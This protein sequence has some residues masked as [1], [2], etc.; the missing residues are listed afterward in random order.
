MMKKS[1]HTYS[2]NSKQSQRS[3]QKESKVSINL[4]AQE[5]RHKA[6]LQKNRKK[7][8]IIKDWHYY[9][10]M[11]NSWN[12]PATFCKKQYS[13]YHK[14]KKENEKK[15]ESQASSYRQEIKKKEF[16]KKMI[17]FKMNKNELKSMLTLRKIE[18]VALQKISQQFVSKN[19]KKIAKKL[20][21]L[22]GRIER[23]LAVVRSSS[24]NAKRGVEKITENLNFGF[25]KRR[26]KRERLLKK[27]A[28][29][30]PYKRDGYIWEEF[31]KLSKKDK[32]ATEPKKNK[33]KVVRFKT[34]LDYIN[35]KRRKS[36]PT[37]LR[38][39][40]KFKGK[41]IEKNKDNKKSQISLPTKN[42]KKSLKD[43]IESQLRQKLNLETT[44]DKSQFIQMDPTIS[45]P[46]EAKNISTKNTVSEILKQ[47]EFSARMNINWMKTG[48]R[49]P[50][51][52]YMEETTFT[53]SMDDFE[54]IFK[55]KKKR[56][57]VSSFQKRRRKSPYV[58]GFVSYSA[59][60]AQNFKSP[61][62]DNYS[63]LLSVVEQQEIN[64]N[65]ILNFYSF[66]ES[67]QQ[68]GKF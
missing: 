32:R 6:I 17:R 65:V 50:R 19:S 10:T 45:A 8:T 35:E 59:H 5:Q 36:C 22:D 26:R 47:E 30:S 58:R 46:F 15:L 57:R 13:F 14:V 33:I 67:C 52:Q 21:S 63:N 39:T 40:Q 12:R 31:E 49:I 18:R 42:P 4:R 9:N 11:G 56:K 55:R 66:L 62:K 24:A 28:F 37:E 38:K 51:T 44:E 64:T 16:L 68:F 2:T 60:K 61:K 34:K 7:N 53:N 27:S 20:E 1:F 54:K 41:K 43:S 25:E 29:G 48:M 3:N 23:S